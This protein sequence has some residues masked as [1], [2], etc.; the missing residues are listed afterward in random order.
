MQTI[1]M[2][3]L[4]DPS[5]NPLLGYKL[6]PGLVN[7]IALLKDAFKVSDWNKETSTSSTSPKGGM[8]LLE[9]L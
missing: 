1:S 4:S 6:L 9:C 5:F 8:N 2:S 7:V 3:I